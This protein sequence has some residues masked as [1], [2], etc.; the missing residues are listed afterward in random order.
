MKKSLIALAV[1]SASTVAF[2]ASNVTLYGKIDTG[3][4]VTK[5]KGSDTKVALDSGWN[6]GSRYGIKGVEDL[7]NG[8]S[9]GFILENGFNSD[10]G[11]NGQSYTGGFSRESKLFVQGNWGQLG[12][13]RLGSLAGGAQTNNILQGW[14]FGTSYNDQGSWT[15]FGKGW[16]RLN[17]AVAYVSPSFGGVT[18]HAM[19][20]NGLVDDANKWSE[21]RHYYGLGLKYA[22]GPANASLIFEAVDGKGTAEKGAKL[23]DYY[24]KY[25]KLLGYSTLISKDLITEANKYTANFEQLKTAYGITAGGSYNFGVATLYGIYQYAWQDNMYNQHAFGLSVGAPVAG[26]TAKFGARYLIGELDGHA[27]DIAKLLDVDSKYRALNIDAA[28]EYPL[29]KRTTLYGFA[30]W[31]DGA[32]G[33]KD[34]K[35]GQFNG[36]SVAAGLVHSF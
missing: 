13:G 17:N 20:S 21:N 10:T 28:Y 9:V 4:A 23:G 1:L 16:S 18:I 34:V 3:V 8:N 14:V 2:A 12:I 30:G 31:S 32:K 36:W 24:N 33:Y 22:G 27:K 11:V 25:A 26:G 35:V 7:G 6:S 29:S 19:Y 15:K 5:V